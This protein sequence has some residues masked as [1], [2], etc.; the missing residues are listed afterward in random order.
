MDLPAV[1]H[2][3]VTQLLQQEVS[4]AAYLKHFTPASGGC[5]NHGGRITT[6]VGDY[7]LKW[8]DA[9]KFPGMFAAEAK[10]LQVLAAP[11][12]IAVPEVVGVGVQGQYQFIV[13]EF[14]EQKG[15]SKNYWTALGEQLAALHRI[16]S[17]SF[18]LDH[19]N[20]IGSLQQ[21]NTPH[22]SWIEFFIVR[23]LRV[24]LELAMDNRL[25]GTDVLKK[26]DLLF[27]KLPALL[28][29]EEPSL[30]HG[31][32]WSGNLITTGKGE[33]CL[34]DPAV[35][36]GNREA[37]LAMTQLFGGFDDSFLDSYHKAFPLTAGF[38]ERFDLYNLYPLLVHVNLFGHGYTG[39][40]N[41]ILKNFTD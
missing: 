17:S 15:R 22:T 39:Q 35:Y 8:N 11:S 20:Y 41:S 2:E 28:P 33:P 19:T 21:L 25:I 27:H 3:A 38:R 26:F 5:I 13:M 4:G 36:F 40:V 18:G 29:L 6:S 12:V 23:R 30:L 34:I 32:L 37:D 10:G 9:Q 7:F 16:T 31:D 24:Q 1:V 14:I